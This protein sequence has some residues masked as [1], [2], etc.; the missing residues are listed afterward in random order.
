M[1]DEEYGKHKEE[2]YSMD[3]TI[4][5]SGIEKLFEEKLRGL[6]GKQAMQF[7][8]DGSVV[9]KIQLE[10]AKPGNS[11][12]LTIDSKLQKIAQDSLEENVKS[13]A[14]KGSGCY[15]GAAV[16]IE[17]KTGKI[18]AASS[19]PSFDLSK[20]NDDK[21]YYNELLN[22][23]KRPLLNRA[24]N[25]IYPPGSVFKTL[26]AC[27]ALQDGVLSG[28]GECIYCGGIFKP[29]KGRGIKCTGHHGSVSLFHALAKSCNV[30]FS[31]L[32]KRLKVERIFYY[33][34]QF[35][36][37]SKTGI[38][39]PESNGTIKNI[40]DN[41]NKL[42]ASHAAI[43]QGEVSITALQLAKLAAS[44][45]SGK[46]IK[47]RIVEKI[48][49]YT[50]ENDIKV[51]P[52]EEKE[53]NVSS[54]NFELVRKAMREVVLSGLAT[55]FRNFKVSVAAKT[56]TAQN[57]SGA[58]HK[59]FICYAPFDDPQIA[60]ACI[61]ANGKYTNNVKAVCRDIMSGYF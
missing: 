12:F 10:E 13:V 43:G 4:G 33:A 31:E 11:V 1:S 58:N 54:E 39:L 60:V 6:G 48:M 34:D 25:G 49:D 2:N 3:S 42:G 45:A 21:S 46:N 27:A 35:G 52:Q 55:D 5:K 14:K 41:K 44:I 16:A 29:F 15:S 61:L 38:G 8:K 9:D 22:D 26:I 32:G 56:G 18:L 50:K 28:C 23:Q 7:S 24:F 47:P 36:I 19:Y 37:A 20:Y 59:T 53:I 57:S 51:F 17:I 40:L 30:F